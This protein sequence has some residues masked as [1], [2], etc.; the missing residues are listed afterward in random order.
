MQFVL[1]ELAG[2]EQVAKLPGFE[3]AT[4]DTVDAILEEA[5]KF[6]TEV[7]DPLNAAGDREGAKLARRRRGQDAGRIQG[8]VP[9]VLRE[10]LE[11]PHQEPE[12]RRPGPAATRRHRGRGDVA[13]G[14]HGVRPV[15]AADAGRDR[16]DRA[17]RDGRAEGRRYLPKMV[18]GDVDR[19]DEPDRAAGRLGPRRR[20]HARR[21]AGRRHLQLYGQKI[22]ITYGEHD[23]TE[24]IIHLVLARTP[25]RPKASRASRCS[26]CRS[27]WSTTTARSAR[28]T[29]CTACRIEH[30]LG[31]HASP[32]AVLAYGDKGGAIGYLVGEEN[33]GLEYMFIMMNLGALLGR[34]AR[35]WR[36]AERA[37]QRALAYR[38]RIACRAR[39]SAWTRRAKPVPIIEHPDVRRML[40]TMKAQIEAMRA[41]AYVTAAALDNARAHP[42]RRGAQAAPGVRRFDDPDRQGLVAP[43]SRSEVTSTR[44]AG[45][46]RHGLH[47]GDRRRAALSR[48]AHHHDLR[49]HDRHPG[50]RPDRPQDRARRRRR[51]PWA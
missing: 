34:A 27:S 8:R 24:N 26:S 3:D 4:P 19:H 36:I 38:A 25:T 1:N 14:E 2:L 28:A 33:R 32:T 6:A 37:Y 49:R 41:L 9:A 7:L 30:K 50:Q 40:M 35:A 22:F 21:A 46:R 23:Y 16:G 15:P 44:R 13:R 48:R 5:A 31:I 45:A 10:R 29:T 51:R 42:G 39:R 20:A 12:L 47:R 43:R 18:S 17:V 11:R